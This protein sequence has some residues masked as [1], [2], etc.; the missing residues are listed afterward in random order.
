MV[1]A[2]ERRSEVR[3]EPRESLILNL[4]IQAHDIWTLHH[5]STIATMPAKTTTT[6]TTNAAGSEPPVFQ[7]EPPN[8]S[9]KGQDKEVRTGDEEDEE[10]DDNE[11]DAPSSSSASKKKKKNKKK[12]KSSGP[13]SSSSSHPVSQID[14]S[15]PLPPGV[16][17]H[18]FDPI[19]GKG[20]VATRDFAKGEDVFMDNAFVSAPPMAQ[21]K[22]VESGELCNDCFQPIEHASPTLVVRCRATGSSGNSSCGATWC[23]RE[24]EN[25]GRTRHH[26]LLCRSN[27]PAS[28]H[29]LDFLTGHPYL[30]L[31]SV[32]RLYA[33]TLLC[34]SRTPPP[35]LTSTNKDARATLQETLAHTR[36]FAQIH[37]VARRRR[38]PGWEVEKKAW[39]ATLKK[40]LELLRIAI[41]PYEQGRLDG[42]GQGGIRGKGKWIVEPGFPREVAQQLF[43]WD[44]F[45][46]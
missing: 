44:G 15:I 23:N 45:M 17:Q 19:K 25:R 24:C 11:E 41:D 2:A 8:G 31:H 40:A 6:T 37:E 38:N 1:E 26:N 16:A 10:G 39:E 18:Y 42:G 3:A 36:A 43:G 13:A 35:S 22:H 33:M 7:S 9:Q 29:F 34:H 32:A 14:S 28:G 5:P 12:K 30:S 27:N 4:E 21:A 20:L 46:R